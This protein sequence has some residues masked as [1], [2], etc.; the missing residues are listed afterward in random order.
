MRKKETSNVTFDKER[1]YSME[2]ELELAL[3]LEL[4]DRDFKIAGKN[5]SRR[6]SRQLARADGEFQQRAEHCKNKH[7]GKSR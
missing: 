3:R 7:N 4:P 2:M 6:K 1:K 5:T